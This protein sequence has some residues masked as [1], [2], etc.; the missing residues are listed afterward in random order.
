MLNLTHRDS[1]EHPT[2][3][4]P[5]QRYT[6]TVRL[7]AIAHLL[8]AGHRWR[9][10]V[11]PTYWPHAWP[12]PEPV[13]L[14][15][16]TGEGSRLELPVR[17][18]S[19]QDAELAPFAPPESAQPLA[20][21]WMRVPST[22]MEVR[23]DV[24]HGRHQIIYTSDSGAYRLPGTGIESGRTSTIVF[25]IVDG[26]PLSA[27]IQIDSTTRIGRGDW[28]VRI[29]ASSTLTATAAEFHATNTVQAYEGHTRV[30]VNTRAFSTPRDLV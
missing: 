25:S 23:Q 13:T 18:P 20:V 26:D 10:A 28:R 15:M 24:I 3:L 29:E 30:F 9:V 1:H 7:N 27:H 22:D 5:G 19:A 21:Q 12:S 11:S 16:F 2:P 17:P 14:S 4:E 6:V 8:P